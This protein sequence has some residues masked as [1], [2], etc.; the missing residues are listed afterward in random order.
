TR[1]VLALSPRPR[2]TAA[3][4]VAAGDGQGVL[5]LLA[6]LHREAGDALSAYE[7]IGR[8]ALEVTLRRGANLRAPFR[9]EL[10]AYAVLI[11]LSST[12][13]RER[14]DLE[15]L[16]EETL[17]GHVEADPRAGIADVLV[18]RGEDFWAIRHQV[19]ECLREE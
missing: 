13:A 2:Q 7:V 14:I 3:A 9:G 1:A 4:L 15:P 18:G 19:S 17:V 10:P 8:D 16:L 5:D 12:F 11:E 6:T